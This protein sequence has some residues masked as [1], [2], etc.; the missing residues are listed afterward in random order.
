MVS[1][2]QFAYHDGSWLKHGAD[3]KTFQSILFERSFNMLLYSHSRSAKT[4]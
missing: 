4:R 1:E 2:W 3:L